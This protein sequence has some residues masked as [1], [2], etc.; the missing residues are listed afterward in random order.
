M[1]AQ[2]I[3]SLIRNEVS[4]G[5]KEDWGYFEIQLGHQPYGEIPR[6][7]LLPSRK[8]VKRCTGDTRLV[9]R[10]LFPNVISAADSNGVSV[11][12]LIYWFEG[13]NLVDG[14]WTIST[15]ALAADHG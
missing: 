7:Q 1:Q 10:R 9:Q 15:P 2:S 12:T 14:D 13:M 6:V 11:N 8:E 3:E 5:R 4:Q